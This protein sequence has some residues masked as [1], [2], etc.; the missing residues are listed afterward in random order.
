VQDRAAVRHG[1]PDELVRLVDEVQGLLEIDDVDPIALSENEP[2]HLRIPAPGLV[3]EVNAA[4]QQ[5]PHG[6]DRCHT[7]VPFLLV[8]RSSRSGA[9]GWSWRPCAHTAADNTADR[10]VRTAGRTP[11]ASGRANLA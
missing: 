5:L 9:F 10:R 11:A 7:G 2:L 3:T 1:L 8:R 6:D 4:F